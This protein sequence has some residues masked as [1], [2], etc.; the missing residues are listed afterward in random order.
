VN[1]RVYRLLFRL[2]RRVFPTP[3]WTGPLTPQLVRRILV[4][5][6]DRVGDMVLTTPLLSFLREIAPQAEIDVLAS[7]AN[8]AIVKHDR[9]IA[10]VF[11]NDRTW[12]WW[13][14]ALPRI[15]ARGYD[16][17]IN[18]I[19]RHPYRQ[20]LVM[21]LLAT[22]RT[23]KVSGWR[24]VRFQGLFTKAFRIPRRATHMAAAILAV[25]QLAFGR[26]DM[27]GREGMDRYPVYLPPDAES[28][29]R[30][31][32][33]LVAHRLNR[34]VLVNVSAAGARWREW[35]PHQAAVVVRQLLARH[36]GLSVVV[37]R[38]P[39]KEDRAAEV[40][41]LCGD[42]RVFVAPLLSLLGLI[43][44]TRRALMVITTDTA[45]VHIASATG[46]PVVALYAPQHPNDV[47][48]WLPLGVPY[49]AVVSAL[50]G[51]VGDVAPGTV[52]A[53]ADE[54]LGEVEQTSTVAGASG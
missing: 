1:R 34:F 22:R 41:R 25:G 14:L 2:Y 47:P 31:A 45:L 13:V 39:D 27:L 42:G 21:S 48:L 26:R 19:T 49:R 44:L 12:R 3:P 36:E 35:P 43:A 4:I 29:A 37:T 6:D 54:L 46:R 33:F 15:R 50:R 28:D 18:P 10:R 23:Y 51:V 53:A 16:L 9:R 52:A 30:I 20:G 17:I 8:A 38:V 5:R 24:P 40:S 32:E 7:R 11:I